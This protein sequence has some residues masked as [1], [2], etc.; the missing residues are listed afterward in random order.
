MTT[1]E[2]SDATYRANTEARCYVCKQTLFTEL[3]ILAKDRGIPA[4]LYGAIGD[5]DP[6]ERP[7][8]RAAADRGVRAPLQEAGLE[9][10]EVR[11]AARLNRLPN[12]N[13]PQNACLSS[14]I[15]HG[16]EVTADKLGQIERAESFLYSQG[17]R[18]VRV[19]HLGE[20]ARIEVEPEA[21][22]RFNDTLLRQQTEREL[23]KL[24]F[25]SVTIDPAGYHPGGVDKDSDKQHAT[26]DKPGRGKPGSPASR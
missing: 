2:V 25:L 7:G 19:R 10:W 21:V 26:S 18:Q 16:I 11:E 9:K 4:I 17:F 5:D 8:Q 22:L 13:R 6:S 23:Q 3:E 20:Q 15:P 24:G 12:W 1:D 14:R